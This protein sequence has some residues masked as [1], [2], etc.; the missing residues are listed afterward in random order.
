M[1]RQHWLD[2]D[3]LH[4]LAL[5]PYLRVALAAVLVAQR[6]AMLHWHVMGFAT[7]HYRDIERH[8]YA[9]LLHLRFFGL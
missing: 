6:R 7:L 8:L 2:T 5:S 1:A 9:A 4:I 3:L